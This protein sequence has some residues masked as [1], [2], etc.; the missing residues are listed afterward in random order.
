MMRFSIFFPAYLYLYVDLLVFT[1][2][3]A[4]LNSLVLGVNPQ[5]TVQILERMK[6][7]VGI[8]FEREAEYFLIMGSLSQINTCQ[9]LLQ[10]HLVK[11]QNISDTDTRSPGLRLRR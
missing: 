11:E 5:E 8:S 9:L 4:K 7:E 1:Q 2:I 3:T 6:S 10:K